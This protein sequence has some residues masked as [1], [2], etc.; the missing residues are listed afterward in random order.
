MMIVPDSKLEIRKRKD[1]NF[2]DD[3][4]SFASTHQ[5]SRW[6]GTFA[7]Y[8]QDILPENPYRLTRSSHQYIYDMLCWY[9]NVRSAEAS[10]SGAPKELFTE[11]L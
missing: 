9:R 2:V 5:T 4:A 1:A 11:D 10:E 8:F 6:C 7:E 3:L